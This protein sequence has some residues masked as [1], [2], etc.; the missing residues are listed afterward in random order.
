MSVDSADV[1]IDKNIFLNII[2]NNTFCLYE[3]VDQFV[4]HYRSCYLQHL[5]LLLLHNTFQHKY[6]MLF[7]N[8]YR[9]N[10]LYTIA[11]IMM[12]LLIVWYTFRPENHK[13]DEKH[14][15]MDKAKS[16]VRQLDAIDDI[17]FC[18]NPVYHFIKTK[19]GNNM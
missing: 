14:F 17:V 18:Y 15:V 12:N 5:L 7:Q 2:I 8:F 11:I 1:L 9:L 16:I 4:N 19:V 10:G 13:S 3:R 6:N